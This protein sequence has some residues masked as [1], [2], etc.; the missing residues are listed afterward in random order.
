M[1]RKPICQ[2][3]ACV[4]NQA[5]LYQQIPVRLP[6]MDLKKYLDLSNDRNYATP[7]HTTN[8]E[9]TEIYWD[10]ITKHTG[11]YGADQAM[12]LTDISQKHWNQRKLGTILDFLKT[13]KKNKFPGINTPYIYFGM[14]KTTFAFHSEDLHLY[15]INQLH[16]GAPKTWYAIPPSSGREFELKCATAMSKSSEA[17]PQFLHHKYTIASPKWLNNNKIPFDK[18]TQEKGQII[19]TF[20]FGYHQG[21]IRIDVFLKF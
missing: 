8:E 7:L 2:V 19:I 17:C 4:E 6:S 20:P 10:Q 16:E 3:V 1:I 21:K 12:S 13:K 14:W 11:I 15:S 18:I 9:L 5:G